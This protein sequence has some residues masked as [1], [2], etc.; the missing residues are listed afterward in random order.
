MLPERTRYVRGLRAWI[1]YRQ[2]G[3]PYERPA[4]AAGQSGYTM[5]KLVRLAIDG[6]TSFTSKPLTIIFYLGILSSIGS[7]LG[8]LAY[9][10]LNLTGIEVFGRTAQDVPGFTSIVLLLFLLSGIQLISIGVIGEYVGRIYDEAKGRPLFLLRDVKDAR[11]T[12]TS[13]EI[14]RRDHDFVMIRARDQRVQTPL[15]NSWCTVSSD[16]SRVVLG[17]GGSHR[18]DLCRWPATSGCV[19]AP[20]RHAHHPDQLEI[21]MVSG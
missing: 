7:V 2:I 6:I 16:R 10:V 19:C 5:L 11:T 14:A 4:R 12:C 1:G 21:A 18:H 3:I 17:G 13:D 9:L 15:A 20:W 8:F